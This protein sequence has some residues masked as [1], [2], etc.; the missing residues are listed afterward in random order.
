MNPFAVINHPYRLGRRL[1]RARWVL[2]RLWAIGSHEPTPRRRHLTERPGDGG[3]LNMP[4]PVI[5]AR[6]VKAAL[7][8]L[9]DPVALRQTELRLLPCVSQNGPVAA[10][11]RALLVE[12]ICDLAASSAPRDA[13]AGHLMFDY[14]VKKVGSQELIMERL[15]LSRAT[16]YRRLKRGLAIVAKQLNEL[17]EFTRRVRLENPN[18]R[19]LAARDWW[20]LAS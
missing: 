2:G 16:F 8:D 3:R 4:A 15:Y 19:G 6:L 5:S 20:N 1:D 18:R 9:A 10:E 12:I 13:E 7:E 14:F 11:L 17:G